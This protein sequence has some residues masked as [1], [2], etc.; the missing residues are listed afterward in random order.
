MPKSRK[1]RVR[2]LTQTE[3]KGYGVKKVLVDKVQEALDQY[4][5][6]YVFSTNNMKNASFKDVRAHWEGS[7]FFLGKNKVMQVALG[8]TE[9]DEYKTGIHKLA[10][11]IRGERGLFCTTSAP[12][13]VLE[14]FGAFEVPHFARSGFRATQDYSVYKGILKDMPFSLEPQLRKLGLKTRLHNGQVELLADTVVCREGDVLTPEQC[15]ILELFEVMMA[16]FTV[17]IEAVWSEDDGV[18]VFTKQELAKYNKHGDGD[19]DDDDEDDDAGMD[20]KSDE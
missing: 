4:K 10:P 15:K 16:K 3:K 14:Y 1:Q 12:D 6:V 19:S 11:L 2:A 20:T 13:E 5:Y 17:S 9:D 8:R 7:R 18:H